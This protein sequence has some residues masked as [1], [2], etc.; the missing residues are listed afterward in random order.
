MTMSLSGM[1]YLLWWHFL[2]LTRAQDVFSDSVVKGLQSTPPHRAMADE[3]SLRQE[4]AQ[5][6][7]VMDTQRRLTAQDDYAAQQHL[8]F[9]TRNKCG[10][11]STAM[12]SL[13]T[14]PGEDAEM[15]LVPVQ[16]EAAQPEGQGPGLFQPIPMAKEA[17]F[18][19]TAAQAG[20]NP[21][22]Q[23]AVQAYMDTRVATKAD[24]L[25][26]VRDYHVGVIRPEVYHLI[27]QVE[28]V[29]AQL[30][31]RLLRQ[32]DTLNWLAS[33]N[34]ASQKRESGLMV[35]TSGWDPKME[36][37][38]RNEMINWMMGQVESIKQFLMSR[39]YNASDSCTLWYFSA[40]QTDPSTPPAGE[41]KWSGVTTLLFRSWDLRKAFMAVHGGGSGVPLWKDGA[42]VKG[43]H[44]RATPSSPQFQRKLELPVRVLLRMYNIA[45][46]LQAKP[47]G[48]LTILWRTLTIMSP[49]ETRDFDP[50][51][52]A[53]ARMTYLEN[54]GAFQGKLEMCK[55]LADICKSKPPTNSED[56]TLWNH[57][58]NEVAFGIQQEM[59]SAEKAL[60]E[61]ATLEAKGTSKGVKLGKGRQHWSSPFIYSSNFNPYP[62]HLT[63]E[64]VDAV[65]YSWDEYCDKCNVAD[66]KCGDY[67][68]A[69]FKGAPPMVSAKAA[70]S[71]PS[72]AA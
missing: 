50:Q 49:S 44:I 69:T 21:Q 4:L 1:I 60:F 18:Q 68:Q 23:T 19:M 2:G 7:R 41:G 71:R 62:I 53:W 59:D 61:K 25:Q 27:T 39:Q 5:T 30:D 36:P 64:I 43:Y 72:T 70:P 15:P 29:V 10:P 16:A 47:P 26:I 52:T 66:K 12:S 6:N 28:S 9:E 54:K 58:W 38:H 24:V 55:E 17:A 63:I 48:Q 35:V 8:W 31:D 13:A 20:I 22:D 67:S 3:S 46:E 65:S 42:P 40:L 34:R 11:P 14:P 33:D 51:A 45:C 37:L 56:S 32:Q 57:A